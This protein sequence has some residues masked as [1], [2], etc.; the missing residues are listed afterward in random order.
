MVERLDHLV[1]TVRDLDTTCEFYSSV[2]GMS[3]YT[4]GNG[5]KA[6]RFGI[7]K[8]NLHEAGHEYEPKANKPTPGSADICFITRTPIDVVVEHL[9]Q[10]GVA[11]EEGP[12]Q[13]AG[14]VGAIMSVYFR[15]PDFN[16][17]EVS[18]YIS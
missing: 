15:D 13:R 7:Q 4:F 6:L 18:N 3:I 11:I 17:I 16:L 5:R 2:L 12:I 9:K 14:A 1:L 8:I 10:L